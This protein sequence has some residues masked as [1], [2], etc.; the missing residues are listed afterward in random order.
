MP[1]PALPGPRY[2]PVRAWIVRTFC[3]VVVRLILRLRVEG[4]ERFAK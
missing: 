4:R 3:R 2:R 1:E